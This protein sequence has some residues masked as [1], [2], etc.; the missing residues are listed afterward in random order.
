[1]PWGWDAQ[2]KS[3]YR[4]NWSFFAVAAK[5]ED[6]SSRLAFLFAPNDNLG[7]KQHYKALADILETF[8]SLLQLHSA[9]AWWL[10][11]HS[12]NSPSSNFINLVS[13]GQQDLSYCFEW[14][15]WVRVGV[16]WAIL[17]SE[18]S[19]KGEGKATTVMRSICGRDGEV[20]FIWSETPTGPER[21]TF[22]P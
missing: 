17:H 4:K 15:W 14:R 20:I 6:L 2:S 21:V 11:T 19:R 5:V 22:A 9:W 13:H 10:S 8:E 12:L 1:M 16:R 18:V 3:S 7:T